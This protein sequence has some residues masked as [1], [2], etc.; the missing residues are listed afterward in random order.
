MRTSIYII[1]F[2]SL[3]ITSCIPKPIDLDIPGAEEKLVIFTQVIPND[4]MLVS[5]T[6]SFSALEEFD[7]N[8]YDNLLVSGANVEISHNGT[9]YDFAELGGG[10]YISNTQNQVANGEYDLKVTAGTDQITSTTTM[11][12]QVQFDDVIPM[13][14]DNP[15][16]TVV[17]LQMTFTDDASTDNYY[18]INVY[19]KFQNSGFDVVNY[20][21]NGNNNLVSSIL[22]TDN[23]FN[24]NF[25]RTYEFPEIHHN[26]SIA[27]TLSNIS[28]EYYGYLNQKLSNGS[29]F[30]E[31]NLEPF[32]YPTN[33]EGGYGFFNAHYPDIR[34]YDMGEY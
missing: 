5:V 20:F 13:T 17:Q 7:S 2:L 29:I 30:T 25:D 10:F 26:D 1:S 16:D 18:L 23:E 12:P 11:L 28:E 32:S 21:E 27:V 34:F 15:N 31:L 3:L 33:I 8:A 24:S 9:V 4:F 6:R 19:K 22:V 14:F